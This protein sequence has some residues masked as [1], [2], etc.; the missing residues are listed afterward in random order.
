MDVF[1]RSPNLQTSPIHTPSD[2]LLDVRSLGSL[3]DLM[4][5]FQARKG[6]P[7]GL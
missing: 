5:G 7:S 1:V 6:K 4:D 2:V 3:V